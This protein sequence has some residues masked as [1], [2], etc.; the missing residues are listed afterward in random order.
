MSHE[1]DDLQR[2]TNKPYLVQGLSRTGP[3]KGIV[4]NNHDPELR[5]RCQVYFF[6]LDAELENFN[7]DLAT[8]ADPMYPF[9][10]SFSV[11]EIGRR[12]WLVYDS[13]NMNTPVYFGQ[14][15][16]NS[17]GRGNLPCHAHYGS[18]IDPRAWHHHDQCPETHIAFSSGE[19]STVWTTNKLINNDEEMESLMGFQ[20]TSGRGLILRSFHVGDAKMPD[21]TSLIDG[22][23]ITATNMPVTLES[24]DMEFGCQSNT[25]FE[26]ES[27]AAPGVIELRSPYQLSG[28]DD[29]EK[30][31]SEATT[32]IAMSRSLISGPNDLTAEVFSQIAGTNEKNNTDPVTN[33]ESSSCAGQLYN[34]R[35]GPSLFSGME[36]SWFLNNVPTGYTTI[37]SMLTVPRRWR[38]QE[39][40]ESTT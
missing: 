35:V 20:D 11:P 36:S 15:F 40:S 31:G 38:K 23:I 8:W 19:G 28:G 14:W 30:G 27:C 26:G 17:T 32:G 10:G 7:I 37:N 21:A 29:K 39:S 33:I 6:G 24:S 12:V 22:D 18:E 1:I 13:N 9:D 5:G 4:I 2:H 3:Y 34:Q 16:A 25:G